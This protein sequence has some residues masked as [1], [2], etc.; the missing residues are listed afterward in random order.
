[1]KGIYIALILSISWMLAAGTGEMTLVKDGKACFRIVTKDGLGRVSKVGP[2]DLANFTKEAT[3][4]TVKVV[5]FSKLQDEKD[6][7]VNVYVGPL[8]YGTRFS[9][10]YP[11]PAGF[12]IIFPDDKSIIIAG[13]PYADEEFNTNDGVMWF[14]ERN[15]GVRFLMPGE[16]GTHVPKMKGDW[17]VKMEDVLRVP[18]IFARQYAGVHGQAY[19]NSEKYEQNQ[20]FLFAMRMS[21]SASVSLKLN[22]NVGNLLD[23]DVYGQ[24]HPEFFP[25]IDGQ[26][27]IPPK[28]PNAP[29][30]LVNWEPCYTADS[31]AEEAAKNVMKFFDENPGVYS[32]S[33]SVN[34]S[35]EICRCEKCRRVNAGLPETSESQSYYEWVCKVVDIVKKKYPDRMFGMLNYWVTK[36]MPKG[37]MLDRNVIPV[38]CE[39]LNYYVVPELRQNLEGRLAEWDRIAASIGWWEYSFEGDYMIPAYNA[40]YRAGM[41]KHLYN[42]HHLR[43]FFNELQPSRNYRNAP[44]IYM[45]LKLLWDVSLDP[46]A[47]L[48]EWFNL[49]VG[50]KAAPY[51]KAY[52]GIWEK[53]W[54]YRIP[55]TEWFKERAKAGVPYLQ[56]QDA[57]YLDALPFE[58]VRDAMELLMKCVEAAPNGKEKLRAQFFLDY[59]AIAANKYF[60][61]YI[62]S[63]KLSS[64]IGDSEVKGKTLRVYD[65]SNG[66]EPWVPWQLD[67]HTA[68]HRH[69][70]NVGHDA[71]G[72]LELNLADSLE[73]G[74]V[75]FLRPLEFKLESGRSY[76]ISVWCRGEN[77]GKGDTATL[78]CFF[79][80]KDGSVLG[81]G[82]KAKGA[83]SVKSVLKADVLA[84]GEW[85]RM[86]LH[87]SVPK[88]AWAEVTGVNCQLE[89]AVKGKNGTIFYDDF[90]VEEIESD[91]FEPHS[92]IAAMP[93]EKTEETFADSETG[94]RLGPELIVDGDMEA[95]NLDAWNDTHSPMVKE[96]TT[97]TAHSGARALHIVSDGPGDGVHQIIR[98]TTVSELFIKPLPGLKKGRTYRVQL[99]VKN[100]SGHNELRLSQTSLKHPLTTD[101]DGW[102]FVRLYVKYENPVFTDFITIAYGS[103]KSDVYVDDLSLREVLDD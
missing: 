60:I 18:D 17:K 70:P 31:I 93:S 61:P 92:E 76:R 73:T 102:H 30:R 64:K 63:K 88:T 62:N 7:L 38:V 20:A 16:I 19:G 50:P 58:D 26:R 37:V 84:T 27:R 94:E 52:F 14:L 53:V 35:G 9:Y 48:D 71:P 90:R 96:K 86:T 21:M 65:F 46:D 54:T 97:A 51:L 57:A 55:E 39:D 22:H 3:G 95:D 81:R 11:K 44:E 101:D 78:V 33:L 36:E 2:T 47:V 59:F 8:S 82:P 25:L 89:A 28:L 98:P 42:N 1:M 10:E 24:T 4:A 49:A 91:G 75:F 23:P 72:A 87:F 43:A 103:E 15:L 99:W 67:K 5:P 83:L 29:W 74:I 40:H 68:I 32:C 41:I 100:S 85:H 12:R 79:A 6:E 45:Q 34:D 56:R 13:I 80:C 66:H 69:N 77:I